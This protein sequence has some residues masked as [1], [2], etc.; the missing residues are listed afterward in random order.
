MLE[1]FMLQLRYVQALPVT[2]ILK[3]PGLCRDT[4]TP[5]RVWIPRIFRVRMDRPA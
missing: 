1:F 5:A 3:P 4:G 2:W